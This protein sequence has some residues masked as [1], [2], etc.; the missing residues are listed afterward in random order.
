[1]LLF[2]K[3]TQGQTQ[4]ASYVATW[5]LVSV[6]RNPNVQTSPDVLKK[7]ILMKRWGGRK[8]GVVLRKT[9]RL[10]FR[11]MPCP[12]SIKPCIWKMIAF[13]FLPILIK[14]FWIKVAVINNHPDKYHSFIISVITI[15]I[16]RI[17][18]GCFLTVGQASLRSKSS[19]IQ[20]IQTLFPCLSSSS[21]F[22]RDQLFKMWVENKYKKQ[23][24]KVVL[25]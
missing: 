15:T 16:Q 21:N 14:P 2:W 6:D 3:R 22:Y 12:I 18:K 13:R 7:Y 19:P 10:R 1:M 8:G 20:G 23:T 5:S 9:C 17:L 11:I 24:Q 4:T 25:K